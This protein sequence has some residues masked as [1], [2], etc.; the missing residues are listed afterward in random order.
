MDCYYCRLVARQDCKEKQYSAVH[1]FPVGGAQVWEQR[2]Q[3]RNDGEEEE[4][5]QSEQYMYMY[6]YVCMYASLRCSSFSPEK[7]QS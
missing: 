1:R 5:E 3:R 4:A 6:M 7:G 2:V